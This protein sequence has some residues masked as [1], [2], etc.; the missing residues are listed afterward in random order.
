MPHVTW[1]VAANSEAA[2][3]RVAVPRAQRSAELVRHTATGV[4][5]L[6]FTGDA[7]QNFKL[8]VS[9]SFEEAH[10]QRQY[11]TNVQALPLLSRS[12]VRCIMYS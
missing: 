5:E 6:P 1:P 3:P 7:V 8:K 11:I 4:L 10:E 9:R 2:A 12:D